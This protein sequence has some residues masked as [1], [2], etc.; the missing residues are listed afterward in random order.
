[1]V[2][3]IGFAFS[4]GGSALRKGIGIIFGLAVAFSATTFITSFFNVTAG[5][6]F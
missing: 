6:V 5:A 1:V 2:T 4:E 3:A